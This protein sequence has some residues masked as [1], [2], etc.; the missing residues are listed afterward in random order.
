MNITDIEEDENS[1]VC[2]TN[3]TSCCKNLVGEWYFPN[4][5][6]VKIEGAGEAFLSEQ[7]SECGV[8]TQWRS[9]KQY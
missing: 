5:S 9:S 4:G 1:L 2:V 7:R 3:N 8:S 6:Q